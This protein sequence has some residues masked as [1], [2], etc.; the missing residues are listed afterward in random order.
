MCYKLNYID[1]MSY[2][3]FS[4]PRKIRPLFLGLLLLVFPTNFTLGATIDELDSATNSIYGTYLAARFANNTH[5]I[6]SSALYYSKALRS[7]PESEELLIKSFT[8]TLANGEI[9]YAVGLAEKVIDKFKDKKNFVAR[10]TLSAE[11]IQNEQYLNAQLKLDLPNELTYS[12]AEAYNKLTNHILAAWA[13]QGYNRTDTAIK[14]IVNLEGP[15]WF[16]FFKE[17]HIGLILENAGRFEEADSH[18]AIAHDIDRSKQRVLLAHVRTLVRSGKIQHALQV[19]DRFNKSY[20]GDPIV[21]QIRDKIEKNQEIIPE[22][23]SIQDGAAE[24][25][26][27]LGAAFE[28]KGA[29]EH[30]AIYMNLALYLNPKLDQAYLKLGKLYESLAQHETAIRYFESIQ[31]E[32]LLFRSAQRS[33]GLNYNSLKNL[34][35]ARNILTNLIETDPLDIGSA[36]AL[37]NVYRAN[38][39]FAEA[40]G[41]YSHAVNNLDRLDANHWRLFYYRGMSHERNDNWDEAEEDFKTALALNPD[42][43]LVL[44]YLGYSWVDRGERE[45]FET[46]LEMLNRAVELRPNAGFIVDSL[47]WV[48]FKL[49]DYANAVK[50]LERAVELQPEDSTLN[51]HLGDAYW[52]VGRKLEAKFQWSHARDLNPDPAD[53][54]YIVQK[55][56]NGYF[57]KETAK[58]SAN[59]N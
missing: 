59:S 32:S 3:L 56:A 55:L 34:D 17:Y 47:G 13:K 14:T 11:A 45:N 29:E 39:Q 22:I 5:D 2:L 4:R 58:V 1:R 49:E 8:Q 31:K 38:E 43:P 41:A 10:A 16:S 48:Y 25:F 33:I 15:N 46:A 20:P 57:P 21:A 54:E 28:Q 18:F 50:Y 40:E 36:I 30:V 7:D 35:K 53:L 52:M 24:I 27:G 42:Q 37:G 6:R 26:Y 44:N 12:D 9:R 51:D 19:I 23:N